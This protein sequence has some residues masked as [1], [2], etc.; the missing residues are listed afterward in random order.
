MNNRIKSIMTGAAPLLVFAGA[1]Q[2]QAGAADQ[3][4]SAPLRRRRSPP[5]SRQHSRLPHRPRPP[6]PFRERWPAKGDEDAL[7]VTLQQQVAFIQTQE[8]RA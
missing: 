6:S 2:T 4:R 3:A 8:R 5:P 1:V 7:A